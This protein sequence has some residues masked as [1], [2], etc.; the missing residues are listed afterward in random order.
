LTFISLA[1]P[2]QLKGNHITLFW[3]AECV[4]LLWLSQKSGI[5]LIRQSSIIILFLLGISLVMDW[6]QVYGSGLYDEKNHLTPLANKGFITGLVV[7]AALIL[8]SKLLK[9]EIRSILFREV[10]TSR[11]VLAIAAVIIGYLVIAFEL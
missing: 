10:K 4:L 8:Y 3:A 11:T 7:V 2:V 6:Q 5:T 9:S 1:A